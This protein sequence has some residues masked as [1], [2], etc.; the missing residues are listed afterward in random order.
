M[1]P[2]PEDMAARRAERNPLVDHLHAALQHLPADYRETIALYYLDGQSCA[3]VA[4]SLGISEPA[5][6]QRLVR[7][8]LMLHGL[9]RE[10]QP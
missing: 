10:E 8:R 2:M 5:A 4:S 7:A 3:T 9:L 6:R 1:Q